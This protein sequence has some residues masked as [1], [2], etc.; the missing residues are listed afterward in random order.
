MLAKRN[1]FEPQSITARAPAKLIISGEHAV[2]YGQPA[3]A[4]AVNRY[5]DT[6]TTWHESPDIHFKLL[7]L[8]YAKSHT[9]QTLRNLA[10]NLQEEYNNFLAGKCSI[11]TVL[12]KPFELLQYSVS[13]FLDYLNVQLPHGMEIA[14]KSSIPIGCGMG[15]SAAA[16]MSTVH[17]LTNIL[18]LDL[19]RADYLPFGKQME[20]LQHGKSSGV[21]LHLVTYGG[22]VLFQHGITQTRSVP[23]LPMYIINTGTP[24]SSTGECVNGVA[25]IFNANADLAREFG[26][27]TDKID[28]ALIKNDEIALRE[29]I[30]QNHRL[31]QRIGVVPQKVT[32]LITAIEQNGGAA[33]ICGAGAIKGDN[34]G[35][36]LLFAD[37]D[38]SALVRQHG[39]NLQTVE[40]DTSGTRII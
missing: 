3:L 36:V 4:I 1:Q 20:N 34:A 2:L 38:M 30:K 27:V 13:N 7:N 33:K 39:Y 8:A 12:K 37:K 29:G 22:C 9:L 32:N 10:C 21:D 16:L 11:A 26:V 14:V 24:D 18:Q 25:Q 35:I 28:Q 23:L 15:S 40:V 5:T 31:L 6:T 19:Q 17:A